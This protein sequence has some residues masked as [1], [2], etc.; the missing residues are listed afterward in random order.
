MNS[1]DR[2]RDALAPGDIEA[3]ERHATAALLDDPE[4][5]MLVARLSSIQMRSG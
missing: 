3:A 4:N 2:L 5:G 1:L